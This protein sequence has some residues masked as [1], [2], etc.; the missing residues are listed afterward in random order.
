M[1]Y[2]LPLKTKGAHHGLDALHYR[3]CQM[4][5]RADYAEK[6][7]NQFTCRTAVY[8]FC[9]RRVLRPGDLMNLLEFEVRYS[10]GVWKRNS[11]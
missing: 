2:P 8:G 7:D 6:D 4:M 9:C 11:L 3:I 10:H 1:R 5:I